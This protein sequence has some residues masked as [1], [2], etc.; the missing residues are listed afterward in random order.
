MVQLKTYDTGYVVDHG[1][2]STL[3]DRVTSIH[4]NNAN[5]W[6]RKSLNVRPLCLDKFQWKSE[7]MTLAKLFI[8]CLIRNICAQC[9]PFLEESDLGC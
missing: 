2:C 4:H 8:P 5:D 9:T 3:K 6:R 1:D 7:C